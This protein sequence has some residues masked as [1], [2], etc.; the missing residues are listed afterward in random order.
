MRETLVNNI[1]EDVVEE[2]RRVA[3]HDP[4]GLTVMVDQIKKMYGNV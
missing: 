3:N 1:D 2:E 4:Q